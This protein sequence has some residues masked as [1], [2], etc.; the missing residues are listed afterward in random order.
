MLI[1]GCLSPSNCSN[2]LFEMVV[3]VDVGFFV[4][5]TSASVFFWAVFLGGLAAIRAGCA[6]H[7]AVVGGFSDATG[8]QSVVT[9]KSGIGIKI[10]LNLTVLM[11]K[12][13]LAWMEMEMKTKKKRE[14]KYLS[15]HLDDSTFLGN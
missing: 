13:F 11:E 3:V 12:W 10:P 14:L 5:N 9:G 1:F 7:P 8:G 6:S 15:I 2:G 4:A